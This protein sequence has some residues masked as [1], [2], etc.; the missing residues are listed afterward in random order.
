MVSTIQ[1]YGQQTKIKVN[2]L[3]VNIN[4]NV[5]HSHCSVE[6]YISDLYMIYLYTDLYFVYKLFFIPVSHYF[7]K[8][9]QGF[10]KGDLS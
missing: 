2:R 4:V 3:E 7:F 10:S 9:H 5:F 1:K 6:K 8:L